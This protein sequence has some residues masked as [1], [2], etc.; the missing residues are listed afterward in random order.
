M[1]RAL[2]RD[3]VSRFEPVEG[4]PRCPQCGS[5]RV[6]RHAELDRLSIA[7][8]DC[9][10][11]YASVEKRDRP[12]LRDRP[13]IVGGGKRG[14]AAT[15]CYIARQ[16]G[17]R[18]AMP[19]FKA[20]KLC[21]DA[22]VIKP[23]FARYKTASRAIMGMVEQMT[24]LVQTLSLDEAWM[25]LSGTERLAGAP[26]VV[27]LVRLQQRI[28]AEVGLTVSI[29]LAPNKFLA[30]IAS[31]LDKPRGFSV[32]GA[33]EAQAFLAPR[34]VEILP[35]VGPV[36]A[37]TQ[38][39]DGISTVGDIARTDLKRLADRYGE[40]GLRLHELAHGRDTRRVNPEDD[41]RGM[42]AETTFD[43]DLSAA[44]DLE[45][46]LWPLCDKL[47]AKARREGVA[48]RTVILKLRRTDFRLVTR[49]RTLPEPTQT[50]RTLFNV[51]RE[52]LQRELGRPY[53]LIGIGL[54]DVFE[55]E[56][57]P[58]DLFESRESKTLKAERALDRLR[59]RFGRA[60]VI[61]GRA[62]RRTD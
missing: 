41:R 24:P 15:C 35:G 34:P 9:D 32:I 10:A 40:W 51:G 61:S 20:L 44:A 6:L 55:A 47:A 11:F 29:G 56:D 28:E 42:S 49:R 39:R 17:V 38:R 3:C 50:A 48:S 8:M 16:Y 23:D 53:R 57:A 1:T 5:P 62:L 60:A 33:E 36:F 2:C 19:M 45:D 25:D 18:S 12:E 59:D 30:K 37:K 31:D 58:A 26:P 46:R 27:Q 52:L 7:H 54:A 14:V 21:P 13:V 22:V 4:R 43:Q